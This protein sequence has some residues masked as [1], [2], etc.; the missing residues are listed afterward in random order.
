MDGNDEPNNLGTTTTKTGDDVVI[1]IISRTIKQA[2]LDALEGKKNVKED[3]NTCVIPPRYGDSSPPTCQG[4]AVVYKL[5]GVSDATG[6][7][8]DVIS[9]SG[10][11]DGL[12]M[13]QV[14]YDIA[15]DAKF[16]IASPGD[17]STP[18]DMARVIAKLVAGNNTT[19]TSAADYLPPADIIVDDLDYLTQNPFE[20]D[21][22]S[23]AIVAAR[24]AG[25]VYVTAAGDGGHYERCK[26]LQRLHRGFQ[27]S[28]ASL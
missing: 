20:L 2:D 8:P 3:N 14:M 24:A 15:P 21:E 28:T 1:G 11:A 22:I 6:A 23:E 5:S 4:N 12:N 27:Q 17:T 16:V 18:A 25:K 26:H 13:L 7:L 19:N 10:S 9:T